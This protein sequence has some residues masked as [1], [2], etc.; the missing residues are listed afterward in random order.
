MAR[1]KLGVAYAAYREAL[2]P[3]GAPGAPRPA[4]AAP[5]VQIEKAQAIEQVAKDFPGTRA[6]AMAGYLAGNAYL[7]AGSPAKA[8][9]LLRAAIDGLKEKDPARPFAQSALAGALAP[10]DPSG[11]RT[12]GLGSRGQVHL[13]GDQNSSRL[14]SRS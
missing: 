5:E 4:A 9:P 2:F 11:C 10:E 1:E 14:P 13:S 8:I 3:P 6:A 7:L 12:L